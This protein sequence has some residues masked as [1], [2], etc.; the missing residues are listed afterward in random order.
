MAPG[1]YDGLSARLAARHGFGAVYVSGAGTAAALGQPDM[2]VT[3]LAELLAATRTA[4][5]SSGLPVIVDA[6]TGFGGPAAVRNTAAELAAAGASAIHLEDQPFPRRCGYL[7]A[8]PAIE[9]GEMLIR[10]EAARSG[11]GE[12]LVIART[13]TLLVEGI[14]VAIDRARRYREAGAEM[15]MVNGITALAELERVAAECGGSLLYNVSGS[16]RSPQ[17]PA[18]AARRL[19]VAIV[20]HPIQAAR[21]AAAAADGYLAALAGKGGQVP[22]MPFREY[23][24]LAGW[25]ESESFERRLREPGE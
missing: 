21:A 15:I 8:E 24:D 5:R 9:L 22:L 10:L 7:T 23:M 6:D 1:V 16:D 25:A 14:E 19:G 18:E 3:G 2:S 4:A 12:M 20:I 11:A 17:L 13:D